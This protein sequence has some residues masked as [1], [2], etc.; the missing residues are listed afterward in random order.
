MADP[1]RTVLAGCLCAMV[2]G[3]STAN[4]TSGRIVFSG[5]IVE[6]TCG[7]FAGHMTSIALSGA[8]AAA[9]RVVCA[10]TGGVTAAA[11]PA[12]VMTVARLSSDTS[13]RLINYFSNY[14]QASGIA[15]ADAARLI[16]Q[17]YE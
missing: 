16:T 3:A 7:A 9:Q 5:T 1:L 13:D 6:P 17:T 11:P 15:A 8:P 10:G 2:F 12:Y 4:A 14:L